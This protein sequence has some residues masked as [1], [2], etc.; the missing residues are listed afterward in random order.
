M[1]GLD[2]KTERKA[3]VGSAVPE[4]VH[5]KRLF[6]Q[7]LFSTI[8]ARYDW[9]NRLASCGLDQRW[10]K[11]LVRTAGLQPGMRILDVCAGT[12]D[13]TLLCARQIAEGFN[14][15]GDCGL[16][17]VTSGQMQR[18]L[19]STTIV[20]L[21]MNAQMLAQAQRKQ[22][23]NLSVGWLC[24]DALALPFAQGS[25]DRVMIGFSTRN[26]ANLMAGL[27]EMLRVLKPGGELL[28]LETGRP[29]HPLLRTAYWV[30]LF[31]GARLIGWLL[32]G[33]CWPFTYLAQSVRQFLTP[34]QFLDCLGQC[35]TQARYVA[36]SGGLASL[37]IATK[38]P[39]GDL[40]QQPA[41]Q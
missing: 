11:I 6:I 14:I 27:R 40:P 20:G 28:I 4:V 30:F 35:Q 10:R 29:S 19:G 15:P 16:R 38:L 2:G 39:M 3:A 5:S 18:P 22:P 33:R 17:A 37:Y 41:D 13:L 21:D 12:G 25:F 26:L 23:R 7:R 34:W 1:K 36:L 31:T 8:A 32:T 24:G 9:F